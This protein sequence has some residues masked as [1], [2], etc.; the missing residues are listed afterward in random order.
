MDEIFPSD[1]APFM[2]SL[3]LGDKS[4]LYG[5]LALHTAMSRAGFLH[6]VAVSGMHIAF[7]V[8]LIQ[9]L[10]GKTPRSS[11]LCLILI[12][13][14]VPVTGSS[15][16]AVRAAIMQSFLL[17]RHWSSGKTTPSP[18]FRRRWG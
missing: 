11:V 1:T 2:K 15:P 8:G 9:L 10:F 7:L 17:T 3:M 4:D 18:L 5:D 13:L 6:I 14:F 16:S 12:W